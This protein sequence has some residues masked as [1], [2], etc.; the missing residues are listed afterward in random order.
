MKLFI[1]LSIFGLALS[2]SLLLVELCAR[3]LPVSLPR[4]RTQGGTINLPISTSYELRLQP[5]IAGLDDVIYVRKNDV[6]FR[7]EDYE[8]W[9]GAFPKV[10]AI[11]GSTTENLYL[12]D[13]DT[14]VDRIGVMLATAGIPV[15]INNAGIDGH[16]TFGHQRVWDQIVK[17]LAPDTVLLL[18]GANDVARDADNHLDQNAFVLPR[19][20]VLHFLAILTPYSKIAEMLSVWYQS[21]PAM[22]Q[23][24]V[25]ENPIDV[26][27]ARSIY[28]TPD[29][30]K[31]KVAEYA[32]SRETYKVR[33]RA[34]VQSIRE[35]GSEPVLMTQ[36]AL[37]GP[38]RDDKT[39][40]DLEAIELPQKDT[41]GKSVNGLMQW[42]ILESYNNITR[43]VG[44]EEHVAVLDL[45]NKLTKSTFWYYDYLHVTK[46]G[47]AE[48]ARI[49]APDLCLVL[50][51]KNLA[52]YR[53]ITCRI[54]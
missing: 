42:E 2:L 46:A 28:R 24:L 48:I 3:V 11:G 45:A 22:R 38:A 44:K 20:K 17:P 33:L 41:T 14:W 5:A 7:G 8:K 25:T 39:G 32:T 12:T 23:G 52:Q 43:L 36:P 10:V 26:T 51:H 50:K 49:I 18:V 1:Q 27:S 35:S 15:W 16:S 54:D 29:E 34:L 47:A 53:N 37:Y 6:G 19:D 13:G 4:T 30:I 21:R 9:N 40:V 31:E